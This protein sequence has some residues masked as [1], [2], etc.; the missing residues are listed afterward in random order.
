[1]AESLTSGLASMAQV[2]HSLDQANQAGH[3]RELHMAFALGQAGLPFPDLDNADTDPYEL[4]SDPTDMN[5][6]GPVEGVGADQEP[7]GHVGGA[8]EEE[9]PDEEEPVGHEGDADEV[10]LVVHEEE[11]VVNRR[12]RKKTK[13]PRRVQEQKE[14][15]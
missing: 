9:P 1:M 3:R 6:T 7:V 8:D 12:Y 5:D 10:V 13:D 4:G 11:P 2:M 15:K 14:D